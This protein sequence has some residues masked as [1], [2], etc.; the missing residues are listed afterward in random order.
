MLKKEFKS[1]QGQLFPSKKIKLP[2]IL[3]A[4]HHQSHAAAAFYPSHLNEAVI[5]C[6]DEG[7]WSTT[8]LD[9]EGK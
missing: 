5:L 8:C 6:M 9:W 3:Y 2:N 1:I 4:E 7:E